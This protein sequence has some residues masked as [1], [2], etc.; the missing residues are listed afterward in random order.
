MLLNSNILN[1]LMLESIIFFSSLYWIF[2]FYSL[3]ICSLISSNS[4]NVAF[5]VKIPE[6]LQKMFGNNETLQK[7][8]I[9]KDYL[10]SQPVPKQLICL[11]SNFDNIFRRRYWILFKRLSKPSLKN[12]QSMWILKIV[13]LLLNKYAT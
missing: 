3:W 9:E 7:P 8:L 12:I 5:S 1:K 11:L 6:N 2:I 10:F 4:S 13:A